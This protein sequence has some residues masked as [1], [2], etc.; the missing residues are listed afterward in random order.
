MKLF[1]N[2]YFL[3]CLS[4]RGSPILFIFSLT[5]L[6]GGR[7]DLSTLLST[8]LDEDTVESESLK[9]FRSVETISSNN[10]IIMDINWDELA[11]TLLHYHE[12]S[13]CN[14][15]YI[16]GSGNIKQTVVAS[17]KCR[18]VIFDR[19]FNSNGQLRALSRLV[20]PLL[21]GKIY[22]YPS[23]IHYDKLIKRINQTFESLDELIKLFR[24]MR[25]TIESI[26]QTVHKFCNLLPTNLSVNCQRLDTSTTP[27]SLFT[28]LTEFIACTETNRFVPA[29]SEIDL[30]QKG[31]NNSLTDT[32]LAGIV[33]FDEISNN[34]D[35][36]RHIRYKIRMALDHVDNTFQTEDQ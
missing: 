19:L 27:L 20:R 34:D 2:V 35:L 3:N 12:S 1:K 33:F 8:N 24:Q 15:S 21:Y 9:T 14:Q 29:E 18:C 6:C 23:N 11:A 30:V 25:L 26:F 32:F 13:M 7:N 10:E 4:L 16:I 22:Y 17:R 31:Q 5:V 28:I 36:P